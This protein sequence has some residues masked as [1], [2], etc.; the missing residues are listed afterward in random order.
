MR[1]ANGRLCVRLFQRKDGTVMTRDCLQLTGKHSLP[2]MGAWVL[3]G[4]S[5]RA[6]ELPV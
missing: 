5:P 4:P 3:R 2:Q 6:P 1:S